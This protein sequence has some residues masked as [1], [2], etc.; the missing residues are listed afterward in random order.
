MTGYAEKLDRAI[1]TRDSR[2][3]AQRLRDTINSAI[4][5]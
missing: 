4:Q 1:R 5:N 3:A 2:A